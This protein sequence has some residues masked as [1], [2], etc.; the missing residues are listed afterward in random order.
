MARR[1]FLLC[2]SKLELRKP[3]WLNMIVFVWAP[4]TRFTICS[5]NRKEHIFPLVSCFSPAVT[6]A[7]FG[8]KYIYIIFLFP[9]L[10]FFCCHC[11]CCSFVSTFCSSAADCQDRLLVQQVRETKG[12]E[13]GT[14]NPHINSPERLHSLFRLFWLTQRLFMNVK[15]H[16]ALT[17]QSPV[18]T[19]RFHVFVVILD[20]GVLWFLLYCYSFTKRKLNYCAG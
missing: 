2:F 8:E 20:F 4:Q 1:G 11:K 12:W 7:K 15:P 10:F 17:N 5:G 9:K 18:K 19:S 13:E 6:G 16:H 3:I 14:P